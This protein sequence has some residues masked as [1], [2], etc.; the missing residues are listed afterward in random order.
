MEDN[1]SIVTNLREALKK[2]IVHFAYYKKDGTLREAIG[3]R[4]LEIAGKEVGYTIPSP[5]TGNTNE[6][7]YFDLTRNAWRSF[8]PE[9]VTSIDTK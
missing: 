8:I 3:T 1:K 4:N 6:N 9:N 2:G 7:A 5:K